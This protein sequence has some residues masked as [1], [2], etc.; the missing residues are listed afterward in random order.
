MSGTRGRVL[1]GQVC[2]NISLEDLDM[3]G[4]RTLRFACCE[5]GISWSHLIVQGDHALD[6]ADN[7]LPGSQV[8][9]QLGRGHNHAG[10]AKVDQRLAWR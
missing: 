10:V 5:V 2:Q 9:I 6:N 3:T 8:Q 7:L 4:V 1:V